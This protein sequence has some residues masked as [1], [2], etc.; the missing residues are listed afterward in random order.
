MIF[1]YIGIVVA[2]IIIFLPANRY[3]M[4]RLVERRISDYQN[5]LVTRHVGEVE[6]IY[7][8]M[9]GWRHDYHNHVQLMKAYLAQ[10]QYG[11]ADAYLNSLDTDLMLVDTI[12]KTGN[13]MIDAILNSKISLARSKEIAVNAKAIVPKEL[14]VQ[15][16]DLCVIIGNLLD[17][18]IEAC[19]KIQDAEKR[20]IRVYIGVHKEM[21]YISVSNSVGGEVRR[22]GLMYITTKTAGSH[23]FGLVRID[24]IVEKYNGFVDRDHEEGVL[25]TEVMLPL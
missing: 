24:K 1:L 15:P 12:H 7:K 3:Y 25:A 17:N 16:V 22:S 11:Q 13:V 19:G 6:N 2:A 5:E 20:F 18:A 21:L 23:G 9:R 10:E 8:E 14:Q 4:H